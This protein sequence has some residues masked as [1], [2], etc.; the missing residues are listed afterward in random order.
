MKRPQIKILI[1]DNRPMVR[2]GL[3]AILRD[4]GIRV[5]AEAGSADE[6]FRLVKARGPDLVLL[7]DRIH[8]ADGLDLLRRIKK[9][10]P[11]V[12]VI[13]VTTNESPFYLSRA[14]VLGCSGYLLEHVG[15][16]EF[17]RAVRGVARGECVVE[18]MLLREML[19]EVA[20]RQV[21][22]QAGAGEQLTVSEREVLRLITE[23]Q[24]NRQIARR[25]SYSVG[26]VKDF[27]Q[28]IIQ[29]LEVSDRTQAAVKAI[30][31][32]LLD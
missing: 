14:L 16:E 31:H 23:G 15:R 3:R 27:V 1:V 24:T 8:G 20:G 11:G 5:V 4:A 30:R 28:K 29:K 13:M 21:A 25:L 17:L 7:N 10:W 9:K 18:P 19:R 2:A 12:S 22:R 6:G 26:T 32:G